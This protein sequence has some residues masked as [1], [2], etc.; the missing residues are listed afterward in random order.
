M[1]KKY[2]FPK[3][4]ENEDLIKKA[5]Y[6]GNVEEEFYEGG[7]YV[8]CPYEIE[9]MFIVTKWRN[10]D[11]IKRNHGASR[12]RPK[13]YNPFRQENLLESID[14]IDI[15]NM[16]TILEFCNQFGLLSVNGFAQ[17][18]R[19]EDFSHEVTTFKKCVEYC[20]NLKNNIEGEITTDLKS[21]YLFNLITSGTLEDNYFS[22]AEYR[23]NFM[24]NSYIKNTYPQIKKSP[25]GGYIPYYSFDNLIS[26]A[27]Y[28]LFQIMTRNKQLNK[29]KNCGSFFV[30]RRSNSDYCPPPN[31]GERS[32]CENRYNQ[33]VSWSRKKILS[34]EK[35]LEEVAKM[36]GRP[37]E[38]VRGWIESYKVEGLN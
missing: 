19:I 38:E 13:T 4:E 20:W 1:D 2:K 3:I 21:E 22:L 35:T 12:I 36:K 31:P 23:L 28:H 9:G 8:L 6:P 10:S 7:K 24:I 37:L 25:G 14:K 17:E 32:V 27:Y 16:G 30:P 29:C 15:D 18:E 11:F 5:F 34:G 33:M 26:V